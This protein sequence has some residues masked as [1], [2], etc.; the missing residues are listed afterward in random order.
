MSRFVSK[1]GN[2]VLFRMAMLGDLSEMTEYINTLSKEDTFV[3]KSGELMTLEDEMEYL[4]SIIGRMEKKNCVKICAISGGK[5]VGLLDVRRDDFRSKHIGVLGISIRSGHREE[6][7]GTEMMKLADECARKMKLKAIELRVYAP[8]THA[9]RLY[10]KSGYR[11][12]GQ[13]P[14]RAFFHGEYID[15]IIMYKEL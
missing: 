1:K 14:N 8:N 6:G 12:V 15:E 11:K 3:R 2:E 13:V 9:I 7:I 10:K 4:R 5:I